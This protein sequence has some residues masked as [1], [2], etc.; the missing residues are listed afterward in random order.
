[1]HSRSH[2]KSRVA[3]TSIPI[4][5][6][7]RYFDWQKLI[8]VKKKESNDKLF[9]VIM[10][11]PPWQLSSSQP[12]RGVAIAYDSL[13]DLDIQDMPIT[14][15]QEN[16]FIFIWVINAKYSIACRMIRQWGYKLVDE[17]IWV[18]KTV[19]GKIAKGHG[20]YL[21]HGKESCLV[22]VKGDVSHLTKGNIPT[23]VIF[24]ERRG[25]SQKPEEIYQ[26][27]EKLVPNGTYLEI[28]G[29]RNNVRAKW[30]TIGNEI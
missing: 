20:F 24:S 25:Q 26:M 5:S 2:A 3:P 23:D 11:D 29:R 9:D 21:Q 17:I 7:I 8:D 12:S 1:M 18:K 19:N 4:C 14:C 16:G 13:S 10:M 27:I 6:D 28:F 30:V 15:L 22:G